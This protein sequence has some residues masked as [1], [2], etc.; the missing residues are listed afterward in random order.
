M[1]TCQPLLTPPPLYVYTYILT[2]PTGLFLDC[3]VRFSS[4]TYK[5]FSMKKY[6]TPG[7]ILRALTILMLIYYFNHEGMTNVYQIIDTVKSLFK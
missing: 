6:L 1:R 3:Q 5:I 2:K 4:F 7:N